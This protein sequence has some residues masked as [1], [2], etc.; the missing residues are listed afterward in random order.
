[1]AHKLTLFFPDEFGDPVWAG[2]TYA[3]EA[4]EGSTVGEWTIGRH[5]ANHLTIN[6]RHVSRRHAVVSYSYAQNRWAIGD[7][8]SALGTFVNGKQLTPGDMETLKVGDKFYIG[9]PATRIHCVEDAQDT[10]SPDEQGPS[11]IASTTPLATLPP[12]PPPQPRT[13]VDLAFVMAQWA[14]SG[15]TP[16]G[17]VYRLLVAAAGVAFFI[18]MLDWLTQ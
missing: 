10:I 5:P 2:N 13:Y 18:L 12:A 6:N 16:A 7:L 15:Q 4:P 3:L 11:T 1:M 8:G 14:I 9:T 17:K